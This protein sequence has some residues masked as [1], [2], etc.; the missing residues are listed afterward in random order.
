LPDDSARKPR[1]LWANTYCL[2][3][4][5]SGASISVRQILLQLQQRGF[6]V[7]V[8]GATNFDHPRGATGMGANWSQMQK[9]GGAFVNAVDG[10]L[11]H[12]LFV[13]KSTERGNMTCAEES[14]WYNRYLQLLHQF[15]P[16]MVFTYGGRPLD[17]LLASEAKYHGISVAFYLVNGNYKSNRFSRDVDVLLTDTHATAGLYK[18]RIGRD[19]GV[20]GR[21]IDPATV[22][23][24][25]HERKH[26]LFIN[27]AVEKGA[28]IV[29]YLAI[30]LEK[31]RPDI[32]FEVVEA[33][34]KWDGLL[35]KVSAA[36]GHPR[37][38]LGNVLVTP[39]TRD[40]RPVYGRA[41]TLIA[42]SLWWESGA[43]VL[44]EAMLNAIPVIIT[45]SGGNEESVEAGGFVLKLPSEYHEPPYAHVPTAKM[46]QPVID[47]IEKLYDH[48]TY[49]ESWCS[50]AREYS[51]Q[52]SLEYSTDRLVSV[53]KPYLPD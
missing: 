27:P 34:A 30:L 17:L 28:A 49:Y 19:V 31:K 13:T 16:D 37:E 2:L 6:D 29:A 43:R 23:A 26:V 7:K 11:E 52:L 36:L 39:N 47:H 18:K 45:S 25:Q 12:E 41:R 20:I 38:S 3:D 46:L 15:Q 42:P 32:L 5:T 9:R 8:I 50:N 33:R 21:F 1:L 24:Q 53:L 35:Q 10:P 22:V 51:S 4:S 40:M 14:A 48:Q 44:A